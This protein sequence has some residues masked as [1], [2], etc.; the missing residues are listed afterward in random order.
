[1]WRRRKEGVKA[2][3]GEKVE[4]EEDEGVKKEE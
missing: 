3:E 1:M 4:E 2:K